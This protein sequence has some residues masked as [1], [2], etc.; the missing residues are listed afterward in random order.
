MGNGKISFNCPGCGRIFNV[1]ARLKG[2]KIRCSQCKRLSPI[3]ASSSKARPRTIFTAPSQKRDSGNA[4]DSAAQPV[5]QPQPVDE[6]AAPEPVTE[7][8][9]AKQ[10]VHGKPARIRIM[11][12]GTKSKLP[13]YSE[14]PAHPMPEHETPEP[15]MTSR[16]DEATN[17]NETQTATESG[18]TSEKPPI[19]SA[20]SIESVA[21]HE[22]PGAEDTTELRE[23]LRHAEAALAEMTTRRDND[24]V[25]YSRTIAKLSTQLDHATNERDQ[26]ADELNEL[27]E[28]QQ[29]SEKDIGRQHAEAKAMLRS[30]TEAVD[31]YCKTQLNG[32]QTLRQ[33]LK[34]L[35]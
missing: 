33:K 32:M 30:A 7:A 14:I 29:R 28:Q 34:E 24:E 15:G 6:Q 4:T 9:A 11:P 23:K 26:L 19:E 16:P 12:A 18:H 3:P 8:P 20:A 5:P 25:A 22:A 2:R 17:I 13:P 21:T 1:D 10:P 31:E 27:R 35:A